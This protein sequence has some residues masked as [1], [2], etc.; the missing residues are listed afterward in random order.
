MDRAVAVAGRTAKHFQTAAGVSMKPNTTFLTTLILA[1][2][3]ILCAADDNDRKADLIFINGNIYTVNDQQPRAE[4]IVVRRGKLIFVG[5]NT[6]AAK[7]QDNTTRV[8]DLRGKT[9]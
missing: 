6:E 7:F 1:L 4:A 8:I 2:P 5:S 3:L 9:A